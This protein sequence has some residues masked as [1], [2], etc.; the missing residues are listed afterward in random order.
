M[1]S[2]TKLASN[3]RTLQCQNGASKDSKDS[4][5]KGG[6]VRSEGV[7][8]VFDEVEGGRSMY[9]ESKIAVKVLRG[10]DAAVV[11]RS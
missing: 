7:G 11:E 8:V 2:K 10:Q 1:L 9:K 3:C 6:N 5:E 4:K